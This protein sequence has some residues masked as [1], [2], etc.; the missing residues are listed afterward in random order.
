MFS[1]KG[2]FKGIPCPKADKCNLPNCIFGHGNEEEAPK[3]AT[4]KPG[5]TNSPWAQYSTESNALVES[6]RKRR[7]LEDGSKVPMD[8]SPENNTRSKAFTGALA[9]PNSHA[10]YA[11]AVDSNGDDGGKLTSITRE[12]SPPPR[13]VKSKVAAL[14]NIKEHQSS[15]TPATET[16]I[17]RLV[18]GNPTQFATR[19]S[20]LRK[21]HEE[22]IR[23]NKLVIASKNLE[24]RKARLTPQ[25]LICFALDEEEILAKKEPIVYKNLMAI[26]I[27]RYKKMDLQ[28]WI[29]G[30]LKLLGISTAK[31]DLA[32]NGMFI[33]SPDLTLQHE[34]RMLSRFYAHLQPLSKYGYIIEAPTQAEIDATK[35][36]VVMSQHWEVCD[37]CGSRFQVFPE[38]R[39]T[40]GALTT[41]GPCNYHWS[42]PFKLPG[43]KEAKRACCGDPV[44][45]PG[46][47]KHD[48]HVFKTSDSKRLAD[49]LQFENTPEN[50]D[51]DP[52]LTVAFD[53]EMAYTTR[54]MEIIRVSATK[55][56][57]GEL[58][59]DVLVK[60]TGHI[61]DLNTRFS[62]VTAE[63][64][65][66]APE[67]PSSSA[68]N[69]P[70]Q[71]S[72]KLYKMSSPSAARALLW[73]YISPTTPLLGHAIE[74][75]LIALRMLHP[76]IVDTAILYLHRSGLPYRV[77]LRLL[78][79]E[80]L[81]RTIQAAG[82]EGHDSFEDAKATGDLVR[83]KI[84][85]EW[86]E[87]MV[88]GWKVVENG[89]VPPPG[90]EQR[91]CQKAL[92]HCLPPLEDWYRDKGMMGEKEA[93]DL[94]TN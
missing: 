61:L 35:K 31:E 92:K 23:L 44:G 10:A 64:F 9:A 25:Q 80:H 27:V 83:A 71:A 91:Q 84:K 45:T 38:R 56:P 66:N 82:A 13:T 7:K 90:S 46:C 15:K 89:F 69:N 16:L 51:A 85:T 12:I 88:N 74:N 52:N 68:S 24:H 79:K 73:S 86:Q 36:A 81:N 55:W 58:L 26:A 41:L 48:T 5:V 49:V 8:R 37:R 77:A 62:G 50:P 2:L 29:N 4:A 1:G 70:S 40:D 11:T 18:T 63:Q 17:P 39:L 6:D 59:L 22:F 78:A 21:L 33:Q 94:T 72:Q 30:R 34:I 65:L 42:K 14:P 47:T 57:S 53:C 32:A 93:V 75:D 19:L 54:G 20:L 87:M 28:E 67:Y 3:P 43:A 76:R 60:P